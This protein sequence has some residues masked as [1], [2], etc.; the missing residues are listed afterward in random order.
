L[1]SIGVVTVGRSDYGILTPILKLM[2]RDA[3]E[4]ET[5]L[6]V[7]GAHL[8]PEFGETKIEFP[9]Y[10]RLPM[11]LSW[12]TPESIATSIGLGI[13]QFA[14]SF[15]RS[16]PDILVLLGDRYEMMAACIAAWCFRIPIAHIHGG[17]STEGAM[18]EQIRHAITMMSNYHFASTPYY[19]QRIK[20]M[21][22]AIGR[23]VSP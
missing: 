7:T 20:Q 23:K 22:E 3:D 19:V 15:G 18:D 8:D 2:Q 4:I 1:R 9:V 21:G 6:Y 10:E 14:Q 12:D 16:Q 13:V 11:T 17:E 5:R